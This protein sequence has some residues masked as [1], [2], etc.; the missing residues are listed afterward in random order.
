MGYFFNCKTRNF[1][2][3]WHKVVLISSFESLHNLLHIINST[4][5]GACNQCQ[6]ED[7]LGGETFA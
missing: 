6:G 5:C 1:L 4:L 3:L 7:F 2:I